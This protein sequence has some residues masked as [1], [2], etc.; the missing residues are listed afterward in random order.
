[1]PPKR[2]FPPYYWRRI[3]QAVFLVLF[4]VLFRLTDYWGRDEI[5]L[6]VNIFFRLDPLVASAAILAGRTVITLVLWSLI[7]IGLTLILGR[8]FCGWFCPLGT[9]L[10]LSHRLLPPRKKPVGSRWRNW[11]YGILGFVLVSALFRLPLVGYV[12]PFSLLVRGLT[13]AVDPFFNWTVT[14]PFDL[15]FQHGPKALTRVSEPVYEF[16]KTFLLPYHQKTFSWT[17]LSLAI[18]L[19][20]FALEKL[21]RRFWC[22]N[23]CPLG[24]LLALLSRIGLLRGHILATCKDCQVCTRICRM[25]AIDDEKRIAP[26]ECNLC[27]DCLEKCPSHIIS[28][29]FKRPEEKTAPLGISRRAFVGL[30][31]SGVLLPAFFRVRGEG[32]TPDP[33]LIR[34][35][36]A[37]KETDFLNRCVRCGE[38][39]K[40]CITNALH[41][42]LLESGLEGLFS[43]RLVPRI[44]YCEFNCTLCGQVCPTGAIRR[45]DVQEKQRTVIGSAFFDKNHCLPYAKGIPCIVCEEHCPT[46]VKAIQFREAEATNPEGRPV[47]IKQPYL[48]DTLCIG[49]GICENRC[50]LEGNK[51]VVVE[52]K[53]SVLL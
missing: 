38:C 25:G 53:G 43:P 41:P 40:V 15:L 12:D 44:G 3:S 4:L 20:V 47:K 6:A 5:P 39:M 18:L 33:L 13:L 7:V 1:M 8:F 22:R 9:L 37:L 21:E 32:K 19:S 11:K 2:K 14:A 24:G 26:H 48:V 46:P 31:S 35:P 42:T 30:L 51:G 45:L 50:P 52:G 23:L 10:D 27:L 16:L 34:P 49:C 29:R 28:F 36:G 17:L